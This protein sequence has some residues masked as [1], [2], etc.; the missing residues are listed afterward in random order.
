MVNQLLKM[1]RVGNQGTYMCN[2]WQVLSTGFD[3]R[4]QLCYVKVRLT[5]FRIIVRIT[6]VPV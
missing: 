2:S 4:P 6:W 1:C 5:Y 3:S